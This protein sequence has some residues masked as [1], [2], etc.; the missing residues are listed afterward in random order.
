MFTVR[1]YTP[2]GIAYELTVQDKPA[3]GSRL[4]FTG[5]PRAVALLLAGEGHPWQATPTG[6][7]GTLDLADPESVLG[8]LTDWTQVTSVDGEAP[9]VIPPA[10]PGTCY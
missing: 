9:E 5:T 10:Q 3:Q 6:P 8:A 4:T 2:G 1:G 7:S